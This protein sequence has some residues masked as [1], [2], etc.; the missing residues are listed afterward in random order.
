MLLSATLIAQEKT[1]VKPIFPS[2]IHIPN[3]SDDQVQNLSKL[4]K[5][6][7]LL[8]YKHPKVIDGTI[9]WDESLL[10]LLKLYDATNFDK[11]V[12]KVLPDISEQI[13]MEVDSIFS[14]ATKW[15]GEDFTNS[16]DLKAY[17]NTLN[18]LNSPENQHYIEAGKWGITPKFKEKEY[19]L[20]SW[21]DHGVRILTL[22]RYWNIINYFFPYKSMISHNWNDVLP[23]YIPKILTAGTELDYK[24]CLL[25]LVGEIHDG[26]GGIHRDETLKNYFGVNQLPIQTKIIDDELYVVNVFEEF[27]KELDIMPGDVVLE[28]NHRSMKSIS[29]TYPKYISASTEAG[30]QRQVAEF[31]IRTN[32]LEVDVKLERK[33]KIKNIVAQTV[34][35]NT[36]RYVQKDIEPYKIISNDI[37][38]IYPGSLEND[39]VDSVIELAKEKKTIILDYRSYPKAYLQVKFPR[40]FLPFP[41]KAL[42]SNRFNIN[43]LG[44]FRFQKSYKWGTMNEDYYKGNLIIL[45]N[46]YTQSQPEFEILIYKQAPKTTI[47]GSSTAGTIGNWTPIKLPLNM[48]TSISGNGVYGP[49]NEQVQRI[50][51]IPDIFIKPTA[52]GISEGKDE[53]LLRAIE[54][55]NQL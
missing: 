3:P 6:W 29:S 28:I 10:K 25:E 32:L 51:I 4:G 24:L 44:E 21:E 43:P 50:G 36:L 49:N 8:K 54:F 38:Y 2:S 9:D 18:S 30:L 55:C 45:V 22:F 47:I 39:Q 34:K 5:I 46:E 7:G 1:K 20:A 27:R 17:L 19:V 42:S 48:L 53:V 15:I 31:M 52:K 41:K 11:Q 37:L 40:F 14:N 13:L 26:H 35:Y 33:N 23:R 16:Q 12:Y